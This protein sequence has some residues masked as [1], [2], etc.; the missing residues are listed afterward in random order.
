MK[1]SISL[2]FVAGL[3]LST[4]GIATTCPT[5]ADVQTNH[6]QG[7]V[8]HDL[9]NGAPLS[10]KALI[11]YEKNVAVFERATD[12]VDVPEEEGRA[13]CYYQSHEGQDFAN[14]YLA[15]ADLEHENT[16]AWK[17]VANRQYECHEES[18]CTFVP[19]K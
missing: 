3:S 19:V 9:N 15:R 18:R 8:A 16:T 7:W 12:Y 4:L 6:L 13:Q 14:G 17:M 11:A 2:C 5:L 10:K 1:I